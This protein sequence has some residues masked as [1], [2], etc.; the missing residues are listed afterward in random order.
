M[1]LPLAKCPTR[2]K[3]SCR[4]DQQHQRAGVGHPPE[5][6]TGHYELPRPGYLRPEPPGP[7]MYAAPN[8]LPAPAA[9]S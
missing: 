1:D 7:Q 5:R 3:L 9:L 2:R 8:A 4:T 6:Y